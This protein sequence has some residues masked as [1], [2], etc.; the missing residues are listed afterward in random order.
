MKTVFTHKE[1]RQMKKILNI[2]IA[3]I[4]ILPSQ[5]IRAGGGEDW[6][7]L[8]KQF[9]ELPV[10]AR[11][12]TGPLFWLHGDESKE[13]LEMYLEKVTESGNGCFTAESRPHNDWLGEGWYRDLAICLEAA[14]KHDLK[15]WIFDEKWWP[16]QGIGGNVPPEYA[17]KR[18]AADGVDTDGSR[19]FE[20]EA[21]CGE[22][23]ITSL[24]GQLNADGKID[25]NTLIELKRYIKNGKLSWNV[26]AGR[27]KIMR[28]THVQGP[29][30]SQHR[31]K[32]LSV[33]GASRD[34]VDWFIKTVYQPHY[35]RFGSDFGKTIPGFFYDEP[36]TLGDWGTELNT[37]LKEWGVDWKKAYVAYKFELNGDEQVS[38]R[39]QY[40]DA[41][42]ETWGREMYGRT[43]EWCRKHNVISMGHF[44]EHGY[45]YVRSDYCAGDMMR[46]QKYSDMGG[47]DLVCQQMY[48][49]QR[50][51]SI[52]QTPK[53]GSSITHVFNK[54]DDI[55]MCE[56]FGAY[57]QKV[58]YPEMK[59]LTDQ[60]QVRGVNFMIPHSFNPRAPYDTDCPP[61]FYNGG[62]EP[63][64]PLYR[65]YADY[66]SRLSLLLA[67]GRHVCPIAI[68]F[69]GNTKH[70]G[71]AIM[72]ED[73]TSAIQDAVYDC[74]WLP[75]E[76]FENS[77]SLSG[78]EI[79]LHQ[80]RY[81]V[82]VVPPVEVI[83]YA[84]LEKVKRFY[85][86]GGIV[87]GYGF[88]PSKSATVG[89]TSADI[90]SLVTA[91]W[92]NSPV[93]GTSVCGQNSKGGK[94]FLLAEKPAPSD[95]TQVLENTAGILP[96]LKVLTGDTG[97]WL[98]VLHRVKEGRDIFLV[99]NQN[100]E[101]EK[102]EFR[103]RITAKGEPEIWDPMRNEISA[104]LSKRIDEHTIE[105]DMVL[106]PMESILIVFNKERRALPMR[107]DA[108]IKQARAPINVTRDI[109]PPE[110]IIPGRPE[111]DKPAEKKS[112]L[113]DCSWVWFPEGNPEQSA[114]PG[115][116]YFRGR[117]TV[118]A[119]RKVKEATYIGTCDN[120][121]T[122]LVNGKKAGASS[123]SSEGW[124]SPTKID[125]SGLLRE[126]VN[127][128]AVTATNMSDEPNPAGLIGCYGV[129]L[130]DGTQLAGAIDATW[131]SA[132]KEQADWSQPSFDDTA[133]QTV[134]V[135]GKF[136]CAPW[137]AL[138]DNNRRVTASPVVG[139]PFCGHFELPADVNVESARIYLET[140]V[141]APEA[142]ASVRVNGKYAG[143]FIGKPCRLEITEHLK[144]GRNDIILE[145]FAP[146]TVQ[147]VFYAE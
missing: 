88:L 17:A 104:V 119:G 82:L 56:M 45:L 58:T 32:Q 103:F 23:Y 127:V 61:Y 96:V 141:P 37:T 10:E 107:P 138:Q 21:H 125:L 47:I 113:D 11:R 31:G 12:L 99:C 64:Y 112:R 25:G 59:W 106:E 16:S 74:D 135:L 93:C 98:H 63:R 110:M 38:A 19:L 49:G 60:M 2:V 76:V 70:V 133:W 8:E 81:Q 75:F 136:G 3:L 85:E 27:W 89:K 84:T 130:D 30:L 79:K 86:K 117:L 73:M 13:R 14:K 57:G 134:K 91:V 28:F 62:Y 69:G 36:E 144:P 108:S 24:A 124:R 5:T 1:D 115:T 35:D 140:D 118:P 145:P 137:G 7:A 22:R 42:A 77:A 102:R 78:S 121:F 80:E 101:G 15:M 94:S 26:P 146:K 122:L 68:L 83:P 29:G 50:P 126:G 4:T 65:V 40:L 90:A 114:Q 67:G 132:E 97:G 6:A 129:L 18:L 143:G 46:L 92:D 9:L 123:N 33:D 43:T 131:K 116:R 109:T 20:A 66:T 87:V 51:H 128:L 72:P 142:A 44:M 52:Y 100:H 53:L 105:M 120:A 39:Y 111:T 71:K 139:D 147:A 95:I 41:F 48:P 54:A 34:C 55:T